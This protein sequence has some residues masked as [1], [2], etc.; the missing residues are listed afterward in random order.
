M[1]V[2]GSSST[3]DFSYTVPVDGENFISR[4]IVY[5]QDANPQPTLFG[6]I[7]ALTNGLLVEV[8]DDQGGVLK[9]FND[10][11][12]IQDNSD[13]ASLGGVDVR[14]QL[15]TGVDDVV[16]RWSIDRHTGGDTLQ[17]RAGETF[18][19]RVRDDLSG[20]TAFRWVL[21]GQSI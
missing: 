20:L 9:T 16:V 18:R 3:V 4:C 11:R 10:A 1:N 2:D 5:I 13:F 8:L 19:V 12:A 14:Y 21:Q 17:L 7:T 15:G 6:G